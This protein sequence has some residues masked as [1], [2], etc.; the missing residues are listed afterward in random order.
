MLNDEALPVFGSMDSGRDYTYIDDVV[1]GIRRAIDYKDT[2]YEVIN[3]GNNKTISMAEMIQTLEDVVRISPKPTNCSITS[4]KLLLE[5][6]F[7]YSKNG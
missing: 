2:L 4:H 3:I 1:E 6:A 7:V 5:K